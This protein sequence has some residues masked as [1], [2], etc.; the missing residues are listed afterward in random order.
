MLEFG[1][2]HIVN[3]SAHDIKEFQG[4]FSNFKFIKIMFKCEFNPQKMLLEE[5]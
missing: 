5:K 3:H 4:Y 2:V 1:Q